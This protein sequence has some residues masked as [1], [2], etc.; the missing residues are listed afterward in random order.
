LQQ[1]AY[2]ACN[3]G[4]LDHTR[5]LRYQFNLLNVF[6]DDHES[7]LDESSPTEPGRSACQ[8]AADIDFIYLQ[9]KDRLTQDVLNHLQR[10]DADFWY[11]YRSWFSGS[12]VCLDALVLRWHDV[13]SPPGMVKSIQDV[14]K[15][16][17]VRVRRITPECPEEVRH[18]CGLDD[19]SRPYLN[20][21][22][23][24]TI[25][26]GACEYNMYYNLNPQLS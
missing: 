20:V 18:L 2:P 7:D 24:M 14:V 12:N 11:K 13:H 25:N 3:E 17:I 15:A 19:W 4:D 10:H 1:H 5:Q 8:D 21:A 16:D 9:L 23:E 6:C 22:E 26:Q